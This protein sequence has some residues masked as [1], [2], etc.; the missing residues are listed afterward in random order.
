MNDKMLRELKEF[1]HQLSGLSGLMSRVRQGLPD[2]VEASDNTGAV[3]VILAL[4]G[5]PESISI[6][7]NWPRL[8]SSDGLGDAVVE[9]CQRAGVTR[10]GQWAAAMSEEIGAGHSDSGDL[11]PTTT[12]GQAV[13][14]DRPGWQGPPSAPRDL[15]SVAEDLIGTFGR[16]DELTNASPMAVTGTGTAVADLVTVTVSMAGLL[17]CHIESGWALRQNVT[18]VADAILTALAAARA[19]LDRATAETSPAAHLDRLFADA[20]AILID[21]PRATEA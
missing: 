10:M 2:R 7:L 5:L 15:G 20:M 14:A 16:L 4:D 11:P 3:S 17:S 1:Q 8:V 19:D 9:A 13:G 6:D 18:G 21:P 12:R